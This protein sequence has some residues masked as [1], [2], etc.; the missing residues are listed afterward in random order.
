MLMYSNKTDLWSQTLLLSSDI[1]T[2]RQTD[3]LTDSAAYK[4]TN[5]PQVIEQIHALTKSW[6]S[7]V[8][9]LLTSIVTGL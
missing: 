5:W 6:L 3:R 2:D 7:Y 8:F 9:I 4:G 1:T